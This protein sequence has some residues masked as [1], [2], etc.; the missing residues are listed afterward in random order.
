MDD[1]REWLY[2]YSDEHQVLPDLIE[3]AP[4]MNS[5]IPEMMNQSERAALHGLPDTITIYRGCGP[6]NKAGCSWTLDFCAGPSCS[7]HRRPV[8]H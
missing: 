6:V 8:G 7:P 5:N 2:V 1:V 4:L 3:S